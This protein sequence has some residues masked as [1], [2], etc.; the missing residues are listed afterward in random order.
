MITQELNELSIPC[1]LNHVAQLLQNVGLRARNGKNFKYMPI[2]YATS[3][4]ADNILARI[5]TA[6][7]PYEKW[8]SDITYID[9]D[10]E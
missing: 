6:G 4:V 10:G 5:F 2:A 1:S 7:K 3:H 9:V 8:V